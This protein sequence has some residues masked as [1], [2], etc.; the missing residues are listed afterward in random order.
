MK[1]QKKQETPFSTQLI[2]FSEQFTICT[3]A[4]LTG[5]GPFFSFKDHPELL[6]FNPKVAKKMIEVEG[7]INFISCKKFGGICSSENKKCQKMRGIVK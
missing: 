4:G 1:T 3:L 7:G 6:P 5:A 2:K